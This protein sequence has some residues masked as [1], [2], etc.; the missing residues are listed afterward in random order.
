VAGLHAETQNRLEEQRRFDAPLFDA[1]PPP[2]LPG[3]R[4][5]NVTDAL[6]LA[7]AALTEERFFDAHWLATMAS[8]LASPN[9]PEDA[10]ARRLSSLAWDGQLSC[11]HH[12]GNTLFMCSG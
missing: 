9:S 8:R 11:A 6:A 7:Q 12:A 2:G 4:P 10:A 5:M 3:Q 1:P